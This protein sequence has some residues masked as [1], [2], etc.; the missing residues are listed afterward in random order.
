[1]NCMHELHLIIAPKKYKRSVVAGFVYRIH[2]ACSSWK[3]FSDSLRK[4]K[5]MLEKN[6]YPPDFYEPIIENALNKIMGVETEQIEQSTSGNEVNVEE[7][8]LQKKLIFVEYRGKVTEDL[9][10]SLRKSEAPCQPVLT[11]R[12]LK[13][14]LLTLKPSIQK[15]VRSHIV[16]R[17]M[18]PRCRSCY[19]G[20]TS[21]Y[22]DARFG[23]HKKPSQPV[24][25]HLRR[26]DALGDISVVDVEMLAASTCGEQYLMT[27]EAL[28]QKEE[29]PSINTKDEYKSR[30]LTI[31]W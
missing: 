16:Y 24:G 29:R 17:I 25:K 4:A 20:Q 10:R 1:M 11:L 3:N 12:K 5:C 6:Q 22:L 26:C 21:Q 30:E 2:R 31:M 27:L 8:A 14:V 7:P 9:C 23:Q 19:I 28:W 15:R 18:C 13:T